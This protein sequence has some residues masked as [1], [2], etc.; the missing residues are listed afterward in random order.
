MQTTWMG[1][2]NKFRPRAREKLEKGE[3]RILNNGNEGN[4]LSFVVL[5]WKLL[6]LASLFLAPSLFHFMFCN[7]NSWKEKLIKFLMI[8]RRIFYISFIFFSSAPYVYFP[9]SGNEFFIPTQTENSTKAPGA[10]LPR[11]SAKQRQCD[12]LQPLIFAYAATKRNFRL[13]NEFVF[14]WLLP[15]AIHVMPYNI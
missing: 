11:R 1:N 12:G 6:F 2:Q 9:F 7:L 5:R 4:C 13:K 8:N 15:S 3:R 14:G 10:M